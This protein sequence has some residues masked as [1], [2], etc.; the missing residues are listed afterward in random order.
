M[1][2][3]GHIYLENAIWNFRRLKDLAEKDFEQ[4]GDTDYQTTLDAESNS[5]GVL[6]QH[7][8]G[9]MLSR[10]TDLFD[11]DGE[12]PDRNRDAEF[13]LGASTTKEQLMSQWT[14][15]WNRLLT[16]LESLE[17]KDLQRQ[18]VINGKDWTVLSSINYH[19]VHYS[20]HIGQIVFMAKHL[21]ANKWKSLSIPRTTSFRHQSSALPQQAGDGPTSTPTRRYHI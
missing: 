12:K 13:M 1:N 19:L 10:W 4:I 17:P 8:S 20:Q 14:R 3:I 18:I 16:T 7:L 21:R 11:S 9:N 6:I 5:I 15:G 2:S